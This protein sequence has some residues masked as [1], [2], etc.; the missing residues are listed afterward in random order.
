MN[1]LLSFNFNEFQ[2]GV[3]PMDYHPDEVNDWLENYFS[4][5]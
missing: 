1:R 4:D 2:G 5:E 3:G